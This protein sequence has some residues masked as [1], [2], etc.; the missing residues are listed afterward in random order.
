[1][2][3]W[4]KDMASNNQRRHLQRI[5]ELMAEPDLFGLTDKE[6]EERALRFS[7]LISKPKG[8][9]FVLFMISHPNINF[10]E[11]TRLYTN[12]KND[13]PNIIIVHRDATFTVDYLKR[14][15]KPESE[16]RVK[17]LWKAVTLTGSK[18]NSGWNNVYIRKDTFKGGGRY[19]SMNDYFLSC[20]EYIKDSVDL[21]VFLD[22]HRMYGYLVDHGMKNEA[23]LHYD[24]TKNDKK[25]SEK[26][27]P[28]ETKKKVSLPPPTDDQK[29][30]KKKPKPTPKSQKS[31]LSVVSDANIKKVEK[32]PLVGGEQSSLFD[33]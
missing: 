23:D 19:E 24:P 14:R 27:G 29:A 12:I 11:G 16:Y 1:M 4:D 22:D 18:G 32:T 25:K 15:G 13:D 20:W 21:D 33:K 3:E 8:P 9:L 6:E 17:S 30:K 2:R 7:E 31:H 28:K 10:Q 5:N 26:K